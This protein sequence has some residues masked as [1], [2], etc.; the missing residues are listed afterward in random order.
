MRASLAFGRIRGA[1]DLSGRGPDDPH[2]D[3]VHAA[4][5]G[6]VPDLQVV[7]DLGALPGGVAEVDEPLAADGRLGEARPGP[8]DPRIDPVLVPELPHLVRVADQDVPLGLAEALQRPPR[9]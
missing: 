1:P 7:L 2:P 5:V 4:T 9:R 8:T 3:A 6:A